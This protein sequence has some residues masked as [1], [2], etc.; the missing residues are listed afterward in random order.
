M[1]PQVDYAENDAFVGGGV[2]LLTVGGRHVWWLC[3]GNFVPDAR[4][5]IS[6]SIGHGARVTTPLPR[7]P[8][9]WGRPS[10]IGMAGLAEPGLLRA[11]LATAA[12]I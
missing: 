5:K 1:L 9:I 12:S 11:Q 2:Y 6:D 4:G 10:R 7:G 8:R 3:R